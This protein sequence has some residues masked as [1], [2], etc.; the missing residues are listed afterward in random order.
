MNFN[1]YTSDLPIVE[2]FD[3]VKSNL[4]K[5]NTLVVNAPAGAGKSTLLPLIL[6]NEAWLKGKKI[7]MLEPR[8]LAARTIAMR[9][10]DLLGEPVGKTVGYRVRF[11]NKVS[12][13]TKLEVVTE[14]ILTRKL[15]YDNAVEDVGLVIFDEFHERSLFADT[16]LALCR[17]AQQVLR[18]D[19]RIMVMSA[20]LNMQELTGMLDAPAVISKGRQYPVHIKYAGETD[21]MLLAEMTANVVRKA[22]EETSGDILAFLPGEGEIKKCEE[23]LRRGTKGIFVYPLYGML[24][25]GKQVAA[26]EPRKDGGRKVV[27]AT[28]IAETSLTIQ[29]ISTVVDSGLGRTLK[30]DPRTGLSRLETVEITKDAAD[31][32][33]GRAGRLGPGTC[34][35]MWSNATQQRKQDHR[36]PEIEEA[37]LAPLMLEM[38][39]WGVNNINS[40]TWLSPPPKAH[41]NQGNEVLH[42]LEALEDGKITE[43]GREI[44]KLAC[45]PRIAHM[46]IMAE[47]DENEALATDIAAVLEERD[48]LPRDAGID[49]NLR[50]EALRKQR[51]GN[52][53]GNK[54]KRI[55]K[56]ASQY[57][58]LLN[59]EVNNGHYDEFETGALLAYAYPER[60]ACSRPGNNA[61]FQLS[62]GSLAS[63]GHKDDLAYEEWLAVAH[64][65][66]RNHGGK[67]FLAAPL[68][69][70]DLAHRVKEREIIEW[71]SRNGELKASLDLRIG[72][73]VLQ[74]KPLRNP[75][76]QIIEEALIKAIKKEGDKLLNFD[77]D[78]EQWQNRILS[79]RAWNG[80]DWPDVSTPNL[81]KT[82]KEWLA[83]YLSSIKNDDG[84]ARLNLLEIL[85]N[86]LDYSL[87]QDLDK[88]APQKIKVP[89][90][91]NIKLK[92]SPKGD[93]PI[94]AVRLQ[95]CFG[96]E[97]TPS[98][99]QGKNHVLMHLL[100]PGF[101]PVQVTSD[102]ES[103]WS[104][105][106]FEVRKDMRAR[107]PKHAWPKDPN[108]EQAVRGIKR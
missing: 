46:L 2:V 31:Q 105:A 25:H 60:I 30:F 40:L 107:Y 99:N 39:T 88:L 50:I 36:V 94:L 73:I 43:H 83:P 34:Y 41:V 93:A 108:N 7:I 100:S 18:D 86:S 81:L 95:E 26:I 64:M 52:K 6:L 92:Y 21:I 57:R 102:L 37:D 84:F 69:P 104:N 78:V 47:E 20:T 89:S 75:D 5:Q 29:G 76:P 103:F 58:K 1:P 82:C 28:S 48:P 56:A 51:K 13:E 24:P 98:V 54:M 106:Y 33:A 8:R 19:L 63:A 35:R 71:D 59:V 53:L 87:Q 22:L 79:L 66:V 70:R 16:A 96:L 49:I 65:H 67:I 101:K 77:K 62:N 10:A 23:L 90:G 3:D 61:Q 17:E 74:S 68:N 32:R 9:M 85:Q 45:H 27:L 12:A 42:E 91:S 55:E 97:K 14:G 38:A 15:Q 11:D 72:S 80:E 44:H 4:Q